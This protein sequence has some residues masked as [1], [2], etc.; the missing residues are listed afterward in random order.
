M[1]RLK[2]FGEREGGGTDDHS[3]LSNL[4]YSQSGHTGFVPSQGEAII[5][6]LR[7]NQNLI[8]DSEGNDRITLATSSPHVTL[9]GGLKATEESAIGG[10]S[11]VANI[12]LTVGPTPGQFKNIFTAIKGAPIV[13]CPNG[14]STG[15]LR[16]LDYAIYIGGGGG[17]AVMPELTGVTVQN[18]L[19]NFVGTVATSRDVR[20]RGP[21][22]GGGPST[23]A[24]YIGV[25]VEGFTSS[26]VAGAYGVK[27]GDM[28]NMTS[29][30]H[31]L[32]AGP[33]TPY[34]RLIGGG[35]PPV[36][37]SNLYLKFGSTLYRVAKTGSYMT[38]E[39]A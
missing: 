24:T 26:T 30:V 28:L 3:A 13:M 22:I 7:L 14:S 36:D 17:G 20:A 32:E 37:K 8:R 1:S 15:Y 31:L 5:D 35:D 18:N 23:I 21:S 12:C 27:V 29:F 10:L 33:S 39:A 16:S 11:P 19:L 2:L 6:I 25:D 9:T 38:L 34:L 4:D